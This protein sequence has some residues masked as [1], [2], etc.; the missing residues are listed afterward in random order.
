M[1][2]MVPKMWG[3]VPTICGMVP[4]MCGMVPKMCGMVPQSPNPPIHPAT[5]LKYLTDKAQ[6]A[7]SVKKYVWT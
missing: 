2:G 4:K 7:E 6:T 5:H 3:M 1:W